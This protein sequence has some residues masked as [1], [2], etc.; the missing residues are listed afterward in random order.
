MIKNQRKKISPQELRE[1]K[2]V[3]KNLLIIDVLP[4]YYFNQRHI[5]DAENFCVYEV[6]FTGKV[7]EIAG[8]DRPVVVYGQSD[9][10]LA[11]ASAYTKLVDEGFEE[12]YELEGGIEGWEKADLPLYTANEFTLGEYLEQDLDHG[13][14]QVKVSVDDS[15]VKWTGR[16]LGNNH[17][18]SIRLKE[19]EISIDDGKITGG[20]FVIDMHSISCVDISDASMNKVLIDHLK[21]A[22]FF[23]VDNFPEAEFQISNVEQINE[24]HPGKPNYRITGNLTMKDIT[25]EITFDVVAGWNTE[26]KLFVQGMM[27]IDRTRWNVMYGSGT[28]FEK[29][30]MHLVNDLITLELFITGE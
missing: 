9:D 10:Y 21:S 17:N 8:K 7:K 24:G 6:A 22:D 2:D 30:G 23:E 19:G 16:N 15:R 4:E 14:K 3:N 28:F 27:E 12:V 29:L 18:G 11:A 20:R 26:S 13:K 1:R 5:P 25:N